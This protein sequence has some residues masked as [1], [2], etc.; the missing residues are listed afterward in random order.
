MVT[1]RNREFL[2]HVDVVFELVHPSKHEVPLKFVKTKIPGDAR[3]KLIVR[4]IQRTWYM[5]TG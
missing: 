3:S 2:E 1:R 4:D 5:G